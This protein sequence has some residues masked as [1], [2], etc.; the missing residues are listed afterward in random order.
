MQ[1]SNQ[2]KDWAVDAYRDGV[3]SFGAE[4]ATPAES[5]H[6]AKE[7]MRRDISD[8]R[9]VIPALDADTFIDS[10]YSGAIRKERDSKKA[11]FKKSRDSIVNALLFGDDEPAFDEIVPVGNNKDKRLGLWTPDDWAASVR[12]RYRNAAD[13]TAEAR[14]NDD[15]A[16]VII[17]EMTRR[18]VSFTE[19]LVFAGVES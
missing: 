19:D 7:R 12:V 15:Q 1:L 2:F 10:V 3:N 6:V 4:G 5:E 11:S 17:D 18:G 14:E 8:G 16:Q 13:V 9:M